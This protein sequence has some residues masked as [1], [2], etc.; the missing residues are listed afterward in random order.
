MADNRWDLR[1]MRQ[2]LR[3][4]EDRLARYPLLEVTSDRRVLIENYIGVCQYSP[5]SIHIRVDY[6]YI[7]VCGDMLELAQM[8]REHIVICGHI[9]QIQLKRGDE[10]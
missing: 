1:K 9:F 3:E 10:I 4:G 8:T 2:K 5:E 7:V 6:G